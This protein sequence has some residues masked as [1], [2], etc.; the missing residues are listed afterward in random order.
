M[1]NELHRIIQTHFNSAIARGDNQHTTV[2]NFFQT[3]R[4]VANNFEA[5][6]GDDPDLSH[7][8]LVVDLIIGEGVE[9]I[10]NI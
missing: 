10:R 4:D 7:L 1:N 8:W 9:S 2:I 3:I 5:R 6:H